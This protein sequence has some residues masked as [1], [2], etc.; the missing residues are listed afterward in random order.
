MAFRQ[1][2][3]VYYFI[4][5]FYIYNIYS[6]YGIVYIENLFCAKNK[7]KKIIGYGREYRE[8]RYKRGTDH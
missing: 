8:C 6:I 3:S 7:S 1:V 4:F 2:W 5:Y